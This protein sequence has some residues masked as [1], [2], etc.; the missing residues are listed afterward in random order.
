MES[1]QRLEKTNNLNEMLEKMLFNEKDLNILKIAIDNMNMGK[2]SPKELRKYIIESRVKIIEKLL[3]FFPFYLKQVT[4]EK[5]LEALAQPHTNIKL[6]QELQEK[7]EF[8]KDVGS[9]VNKIHKE[10]KYK[11]EI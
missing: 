9:R 3:K 7:N 2:I 1:D 11:L 8:L 4:I 6:N 10:L 5:P